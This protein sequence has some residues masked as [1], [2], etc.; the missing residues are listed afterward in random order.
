MRVGYRKSGREGPVERLGHDPTSPWWGIHVARYR[1]AAPYAVQRRTLDIACGTGYGLPELQKR[2]RC[3]IGVDLDREAARAARAEINSG[4]GAV[5]VAD[6]AALPFKEKS[7]ELITSF[8][9]L[10]HLKHRREFLAELRRVLSAEG[11]C[12]LS[13]PNAN[14]TLPINGTPRNPHHL[15]EYTPAELDNELRRCFAQVELIGQTLDRRFLIPPFWDEQ[16]Q[17]PETFRIQAQLL[18]W[19]VLNKLPARLRDR[20]S[21]M[22]WGHPFL[23]SEGDYRFARSGVE[24]APVLVALCRSA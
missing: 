5:L 9:T 18:L 1:F 19:R 6:G 13:T 21:L 20:L 12:I 4:A 17:L 3:V 11:L 14:R 22:V 16:Q 24:A 23:P 2:A 7:F 15:H 8:E 10:E